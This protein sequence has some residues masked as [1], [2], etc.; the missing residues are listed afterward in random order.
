[1][2]QVQIASRLYGSVVADA[3]QSSPCLAL[4]LRLLARDLVLADIGGWHD[5]GSP[6]K[7]HAI[8]GYLKLRIA[9]LFLNQ[10]SELIINYCKQSSQVCSPIKRYAWVLIIIY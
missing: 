3:N 9:L 10:S 7:Q 2:D 4:T 5:D 8:A 1:M 6:A